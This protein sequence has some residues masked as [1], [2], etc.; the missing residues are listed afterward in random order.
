MYIGTFNCEDVLT[1]VGPY[2]A[3]MKDTQPS[4]G[5]VVIYRGMIFIFLQLIAHW[6]LSMMINSLTIQPIIL[7]SINGVAL[8]S[9]VCDDFENSF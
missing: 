6:A 4:R 9:V 7:Q 3:N 8:D 1:W 2:N 5:K